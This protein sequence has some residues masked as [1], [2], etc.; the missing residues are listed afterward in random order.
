MTTV[1]EQASFARVKSGVG[2]G[3][4]GHSVPSWGRAE[5]SAPQV[6]P[7]RLQL[8]CDIHQGFDIIVDIIPSSPGPRCPHQGFDIVMIST[9]AS[10]M[11]WPSSSG[12]SDCLH[13][14]AGSHLLVPC[15][16][17]SL[18]TFLCPVCLSVS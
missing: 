14:L 12:S 9:K 7:S 4:A 8:P 11:L 6:S 18:L 3:E 13:I 17:L 15:Q 1:G 5:T 2:M 16:D 10:T